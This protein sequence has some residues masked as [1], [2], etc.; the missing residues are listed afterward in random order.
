L[1]HADSSVETTS[2]ASLRLARCSCS[3]GDGL[4]PDHAPGSV[5]AVVE[6]GI[7]QT[8]HRDPR[9]HVRGADE[10][11]VAEIKADVTRPVEEEQVARLQ[12]RAPNERPTSICPNDDRG[13]WMPRRL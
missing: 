13:S 2:D 5:V 12:A 3:T 8:R 6:P 11:A 9:S 1:R 7:A 4:L 10:L